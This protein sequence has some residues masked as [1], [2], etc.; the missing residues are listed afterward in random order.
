MTARLR[1]SLAA[2]RL[3]PPLL[4][5]LATVMLAAPMLL[6]LTFT[7]G[8]VADRS[9]SR[10]AVERQQTA[11]V[12]GR[13]IELTLATAGEDLVS[14]GRDVKASLA[15][16]DHAALQSALRELRAISPLYTNVAAFDPAG[17]M[18]ARDPDPGGLVGLSFAA[19][20]YYVGATASRTPF[21]SGLFRSLVPP[22]TPLV[23][24]SY[25]IRD[26]DRIIGLLNITLAPGDLL[27]ALEPVLAVPGRH[28]LITDR[29]GRVVASSAPGQ[30]ALTDAALVTGG[31]ARFVAAA[32]IASTGWTLHITDSQSSVL[33][34]KT[35]LDRDLRLGALVT[36]VAALGFGRFLAS[37]YAKVVRQ[38]DALV[39]AQV[40]LT[41]V[42][43]ELARADR[44]KSAF[45]SDMSHELRTPMNAILGFS[46]LLTEQLS[47]TLTERQKRFFWNI[48]TAGEHLLGLINDALD[49]SKVESGRIELLPEV[50]DLAALV[51]PAIEA[52][53]AD[54]E[55]AGL[56]LVASD[57]PGGLVRL[58]VART[59]QILESLL[60]NALKFTPAPGTITVSVAFEGESAIMTVADTGIGIASD[61]WPRVFGLFERVNRER[62]DVPGAGLGLAL[63][64]RLVELQG[65]TIDFRSTVDVGSSFTVRFPDV[66][67]SVVVSEAILI[68][69]DEW[70]D[71]ELLEALASEAGLASHRVATLAEAT[72]AIRT[73]RPLGV[74]LDL[75]LPDG[76]GSSILE[77]LKS[78]AET[79]DVP[80]LVV[81]SATETARFRL[82]GAECMT[83][84]IDAAAIRAWLARVAPPLAA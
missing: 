69:E 68:V 60:S 9:V 39:T 11:A 47:P 84:P 20:D 12:G 38:R 32:P 63:T 41:D 79:A 64:K 54:A 36:L 40:G 10:Q 56:T 42:N 7:S 2:A 17:V 83:K 5:L 37:L 52:A 80:V 44:A 81:T 66:R 23:A 34:V 62:S 76:H 74:I 29:E 73:A 77:S 14:R 18:L 48:R 49:L 13:L 19:R 71:A 21:V 24:V 30:A 82:M 70:I 65:G 58:D 31:D 75:F 72:A 1:R 55:H 78:S 59:R 27:R 35:E 57:P 53:R 28:L 50:I 67:Y 4:V 25:A 16:A 61:D 45:L 6:L 46:A 51:E 8:S 43:A 22:F 3:G 26:G 15:T 33:A